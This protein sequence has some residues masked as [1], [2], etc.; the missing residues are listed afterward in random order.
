MQVRRQAD[1]PRQELAE[2]I[3][4]AD[5]WRRGGPERGFSMASG[6]LGN[7][8]DARTVI[9]TAHDCSGRV[10]GLLSFVPWGRR[11][12][13][14]DLMRRS[15]EAISGVTELMVTELIA[16][17]DQLG[18]TQISL[19][20]AMFRESF[21]R[22][23]RIGASPLQRLNRKLLV[24]ASR[25]WQLHSLYQSNEKYRPRWRP[26]LL[27]YDSTAQLTRGRRQSRTSH[28]AHPG[29]AAH[30]TARGR[31]RR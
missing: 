20:F 22:G 11:D 13:S 9:V 16:A 15:P 10:C 24:F 23:A 4:V 2:L 31:R 8:R 7:A 3:A 17:A 29:A 30:S 5:V 25:W 12:L 14:L 27:C 19:N 6:R 26:R 18:V 21:A 28:P 1:I